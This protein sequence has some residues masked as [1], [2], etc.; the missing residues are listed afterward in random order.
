MCSNN[1]LAI[2]KDKPDVTDLLDQLIR[3][4]EEEFYKLVTVRLKIDNPETPIRNNY[5]LTASG[6]ANGTKPEWGPEPT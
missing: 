5:S 2:A 1:K 3:L 6:I 4:P